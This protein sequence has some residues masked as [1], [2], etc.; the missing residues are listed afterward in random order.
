LIA[1]PWSHPAVAAIAQQ[2]AVRTGLAFPEQRQDSAELGIRRAM[3]RAGVTELERYAQR[4]ETDRASLE[5]LIAE[6]TVGETYFFREWPQFEFIRRQVLPEIQQRR[7]GDAVFR[8]WSAG[9]A[10][11][12]E[13][14]SL[15]I[16]LETEGLQDRAH[17]LATDISREALARAEAG[18]YRSWSLRDQGA[19]I[20]APYLC[21]SGD[22]FV[23]AERIRRRVSFQYLTLPRM[24]TPR[25]RRAHGGWT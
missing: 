18:R 21:R 19:Q 11:G 6:L 16:L 25:W 1:M 24:C 10:S 9:C 8:I 17:I 22:T 14:Y 3:S 15:A 7:G 5:E 23:L 13:P 2:V 20:V 12:E 4:I